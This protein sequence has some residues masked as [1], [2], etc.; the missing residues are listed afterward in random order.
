MKVKEESE[1]TGLKLNIQNIKIMALG[2]NNSWQTD[3]ETREKVTDFMLL[4]SKITADS[5][6]SHGIKRHLLPRS[7]TMTNLDSILK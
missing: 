2:P 4:G 3:G 7:K 1:I 6:C 5:D